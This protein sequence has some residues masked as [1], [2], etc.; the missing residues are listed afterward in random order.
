MI[1]ASAHQV[2]QRRLMQALF[3]PAGFA[4]ATTAGTVVQ[5]GGKYDSM[6]SQ[7]KS[8]ADKDDYAYGSVSDDD[9]VAAADELIAEHLQAGYVGHDGVSDR[10]IPATRGSAYSGHLSR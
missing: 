1:H 6:F 7:A 3:G 4:P 9:Y 2:A 5:L 10:H 8:D